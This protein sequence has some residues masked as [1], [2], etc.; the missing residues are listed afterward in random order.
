MTSMKRISRFTGMRGLVAFGLSELGLLAI[1]YFIVFRMAACGGLSPLGTALVFYLIW[2]LSTL[3][4][5]RLLTLLFPLRD[6]KFSL[7]CR[8]RVSL[9]WTLLGQISFCNLFPYFSDGIVPPVLKP[10]FYRILGS[11]IGR[12]IVVLGGR[13]TD[14]WLVTLEEGAIVGDGALILSHLVTSG[15]TPLILGSVLLKKNCLIGVRSVILPGVTVGE[16]SLVQPMS[17]VKVATIIPANEIWG[18]VPAKK[19][20]DREL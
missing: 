16:N 9:V 15:P 6:G 19:L 10:W 11:R 8:D 20:G 13:F 4:F 17:L 12:G 1:P 18:G 2:I 14:P 5:L 7:D 3:V